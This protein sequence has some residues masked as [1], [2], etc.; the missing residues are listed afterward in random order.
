MP[1]RLSD[2]ASPAIPRL[3]AGLDPFRLTLDE[4][5]YDIYVT[6]QGEKTVLTG[7]VA[8]DLALGDVFDMIIYENADP[9]VVDLLTIPI[10]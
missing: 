3:Q 6:V 5:S 7:P 8:L 1:C 2:E 4:G 10:P 9:N